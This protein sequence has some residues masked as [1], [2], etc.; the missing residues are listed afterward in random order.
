MNQR[1][2]ADRIGN[3]DGQ[4]IEEARYHRLRKSGGFQHFLAAAA[5]A[6]LMVISFTVGALA[7]GR[8][9]PIEKE[10]IELPGIGLTLILP[11]SWKGAYGVE[12]NEDASQCSVYVKS[13][14]EKDPTWGGTLF[15]VDRSYDRP[16]TPEE[17]Y[18]VSPV[19]C[20]YLFSTAGGTYSMDYA[21]D[22]QW[23]IEDPEQEQ[24]YRKMQTE[25]N[26]IRFV[27]DNILT[28][29]G[30]LSDR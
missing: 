1:Q 6:A 13:I 21:S 7:F 24:R 16:M 2:F 8:E 4:L 11:D 15:R 12:I 26:Q 19:D 30:A 14:R 23:N 27:V 25:I 20:R 10:T 17:L 3:I 18:E 5:V 29:E 22:M 9:V 28:D